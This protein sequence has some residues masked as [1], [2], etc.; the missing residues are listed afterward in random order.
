MV[1]RAVQLE[2]DFSDST[3]GA[4]MHPILGIRAGNGSDERMDEYS[5]PAV[6]ILVSRSFGDLTKM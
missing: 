6:G 4:G 1:R 2:D 5:K 3:C